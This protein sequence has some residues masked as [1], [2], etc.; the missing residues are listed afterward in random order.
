MKQPTTKEITVLALF[1]AVIVFL[2]FMPLRTLGLE[3]T[4]TMVPIAV[5]AILY[6]PAAGAVLG[7]VF[8]LVS[9]AQCFFGYSPFGATLYA[10]NPFLTVMVCIPP[11][12]L[13]G[14][15][16]GLLYKLSSKFFKKGNISYIIGCFTAPLLNTVFFMST[17]VLFFYKTDY[18]QGFVSFLG[19]TNPVVF[20]ILF[21]GINGLVELAAGFIIALPVT[22]ALRKAKL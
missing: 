3:I 14:W 21:V 8:G 13:A 19:A 1:S 16:A 15:I 22:L 6:G 12:V 4:F 5:G 20:I 11:R 7:G 10:I 2:A 17:L 18:I 9:F